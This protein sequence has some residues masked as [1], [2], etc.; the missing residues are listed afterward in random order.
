MKEKALL[1]VFTDEIRHMVNMRFDDIE[2]D[3]DKQYGLEELNGVNPLEL[4]EA[5]KNQNLLS[6]KEDDF[7]TRMMIENSSAPFNSS[8]KIVK[9][10]IVHNVLPVYSMEQT[11]TFYSDN[12]SSLHVVH[13]SKK[14]LMLEAKIIRELSAMKEN[15]SYF[16]GTEKVPAHLALMGVANE[17]TASRRRPRNG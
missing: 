6:E 5:K 14:E 13:I 4:Q 12:M 9:M 2:C 17:H 10:D 15:G 7:H 3:Y 8:G 16:W 1:P 11:K